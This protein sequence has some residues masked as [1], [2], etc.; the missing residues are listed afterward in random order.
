MLSP[1][2][3]A[4]IASGRIHLLLPLAEIARR[5]V[6]LAQAVED[7][8][9][10]A[11]LCIAVERD[12]LGLI[13]LHHSIEQTQHAGVNQVVEIHMH[14][15]VLVHANGDRFDQRKMFEHDLVANLDG[16]SRPPAYRHTWHPHRFSP[17]IG[18]FL[19]AG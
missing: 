17:L 7:G 19:G 12:A 1:I 15:Q 14:R 13:V 16:N 3:C 6:E 18:S 5:P 4:K 10:D 8:A 11:V 9:F 2:S